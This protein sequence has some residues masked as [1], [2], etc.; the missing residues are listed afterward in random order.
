[1]VALQSNLYGLAVMWRDDMP[2]ISARWVYMAS[3]RTRRAEPRDVTIERTRACDI[4]GA[5]AEFARHLKTI[6]SSADARPNT[7]ACGDYGG[8]E[9]RSDLGGP[10][11]AKRSVGALIQ[12]R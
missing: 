8:C 1:A 6:P 4:V 9:F 2:R 12:A 11:R 7:N 10:C 5:A 3:K